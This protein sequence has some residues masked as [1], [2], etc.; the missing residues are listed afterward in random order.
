MDKLPPGLCFFVQEIAA[1]GAEE[2]IA[3][4]SK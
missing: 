4:R 3:Y 1:K 2:F